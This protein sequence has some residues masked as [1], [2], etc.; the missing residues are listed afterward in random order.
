MIPAPPNLLRGG[1][2]TNG[3]FNS[4]LYPLFES[5]FANSFK[6]EWH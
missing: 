4:M 5:E 1:I 6:I 2:S 3:S